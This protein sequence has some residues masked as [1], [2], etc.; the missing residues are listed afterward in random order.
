MV[1]ISSQP[2]PEKKQRE[3][4]PPTPKIVP[5]KEPPPSP[6]YSI[7]QEYKLD[8]TIFG[9]G[10]F[11]LGGDLNEGAKG[12][13]AY[14]S[15]SL[16]LEGVGQ[17]KPIRLSYIFGG[18]VSYPLSPHFSLGLGLGYFS[19]AKESRVEFQSPEAADIYLTKP[20]IRVIPLKV[21]LTFYPLSSFYLKAVSEHYFGR[22]SYLYRY[23]SQE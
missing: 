2:V 13:A 9:G 4:Q 8:F 22:C 20:E 12:L 14:Y 18:E 7:A 6:V 5:E 17:V 15:D 23:Q 1:V 3:E 21:F 11:I 16:A 19:G 10:N